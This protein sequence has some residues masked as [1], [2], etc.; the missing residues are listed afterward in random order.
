MIR[1]PAVSRDKPP[2]PPEEVTEGPLA[3]AEAILLRRAV[4]AAA[5]AG[6]FRFNARGPEDLQM[7]GRF[8]IFFFF[9]NAAL[10]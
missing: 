3:Q 9:A 8:E 6:D 1:T 10:K 2:P 4:R 7:H 5:A